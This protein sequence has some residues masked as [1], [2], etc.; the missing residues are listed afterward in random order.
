MASKKETPKIEYESVKIRK[1]VVEKVREHKKKTYMPI[2]IFFELAA[3][4]K[5][6]STK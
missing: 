1:E 2:A 3:Q 4:E 6:K 5:L